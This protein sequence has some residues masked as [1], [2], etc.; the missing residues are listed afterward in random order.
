[1]AKEKM[2]A[3]LKAKLK[4]KPTGKPRGPVPKYEGTCKRRS[5]SI[6]DELWSWCD[7]ASVLE[8]D[9]LVSSA[10][11]YI[12]NLIRKERARLEKRRVKQ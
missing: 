5:L 6:P 9:A 3:E 12:C 7:E 4:Y 1:M 8:G 10:S 2:S 11:E